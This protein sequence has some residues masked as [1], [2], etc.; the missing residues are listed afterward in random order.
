[1]P[2]ALMIIPWNP[3]AHSHCLSVI[4]LN[5]GIIVWQPPLRH[6]SLEVE[7]FIFLYTSVLQP[8]TWQ[9]LLEAWLVLSKEL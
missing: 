7:N 9:K 2:L 6:T 4:W 8:T 3:P 5:L 1:M